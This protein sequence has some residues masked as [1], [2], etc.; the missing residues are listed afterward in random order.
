MSPAD[1][2]DKPTVVLDLNA[3]KKQKLF[4]EEKLANIEEDI[5]FDVHAQEASENTITTVGVLPQKDRTHSFVAAPAPG[6]FRPG[7]MP[8]DGACVP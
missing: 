2:D 1:E 4:E 3:L 8:P 7:A 6:K 5:Q